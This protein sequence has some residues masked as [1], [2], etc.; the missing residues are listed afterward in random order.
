MYREN[1]CSIY[2]QRILKKGSNYDS[3][4]TRIQNNRP[5]YAS[6]K[7]ADGE[8]A[9][10]VVICGYQA[11]NGGY[12]YYILMDP[13]RPQKVTVQIPSSTATTFTYAS[14]EHTYTNWYRQFS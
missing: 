13:N 1:Y 4:K 6:L 8:N 9:H 10:A 2:Q 3:V 14:G 5:I 11:Y 7:T 12:H